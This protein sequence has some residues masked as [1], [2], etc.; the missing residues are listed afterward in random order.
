M[1]DLPNTSCKRRDRSCAGEASD[2]ADDA[3]AAH[4]VRRISRL[5]TWLSSCFF[6]SLEAAL[7]MLAKGYSKVTWTELVVEVEMQARFDV[8]RGV[9]AKVL[10]HTARQPH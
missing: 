4:G 10:P 2:A 9:I 3:Q 6:L 1:Y 8:E 7:T 5:R